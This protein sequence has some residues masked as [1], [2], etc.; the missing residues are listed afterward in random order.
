MRLSLRI[1]FNWHKL[2]CHG[3]LSLGAFN[4]N[5]TPTSLASGLCLGPVQSVVVF[6]LP[7]KT[8][9]SLE[10]RFL[11]GCCCFPPP[12]PPHINIPVYFGLQKRPCSKFTHNLI[13]IAVLWNVYGDC[14]N[15]AT[16]KGH[17][18]AVMEL[19]Y[20]TDGRLVRQKIFHC[21]DCC[22]S[23]W[24]SFSVRWT[25]GKYMHWGRKEMHLV[26]SYGIVE[27]PLTPIHRF[28]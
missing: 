19:H 18:G 26:L 16:L 9:N 24:S 10:P 12:P 7:F 1:V 20:N 27:K 25:S 14:D 23:R 13:W 22:Y 3:S 4:T 28:I 6:V 2:Y 8:V 11:K 21:F 5:T 17:S 15:Y